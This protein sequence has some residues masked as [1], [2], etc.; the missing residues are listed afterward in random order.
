MLVRRHFWRM[1]RKSI[2]YFLIAAANL[3]ILTLLL[4]LWTDEFERQFNLFV[5]PGEFLK[6]IAF[7]FL[8]LIGMRI[9]V[10]YFRKK[11]IYDTRRKIKY[12]TIL[13]ILICLVLYFNYTIKAV[14]NR[15][16]NATTREHIFGKLKST[17]NAK[18]DSLFFDEYKEIMRINGFPKIPESS[19]NISVDYYEDGFLPDFSISVTYEVPITEII[20]EMKYKNGQYSKSI[21]VEVIG[22][23]KKVYYEEGEW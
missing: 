14:Q 15:L 7:T 10:V 3:A 2:K 13:T 18:V 20:S 1:I 21:T 17:N 4:A 5:R 11:K 22:Q 9:L 12:A 23:H 16:V 19:K 6:I 8:A